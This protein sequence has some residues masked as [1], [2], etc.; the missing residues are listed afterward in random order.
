MSTSG[1]SSIF[2]GIAVD[3]DAVLD[4]VKVK[5]FE[6]DI[7]NQDWEVH[8]VSGK[9]LWKTEFH[10]KF[11]NPCVAGYEDVDLGL[12]QGIT[13]KYL[14]VKH[15]KN[16]AEFWS[17]EVP[18]LVLIGKEISSASSYRDESWS[19]LS[20]TQMRDEYRLCKI[21]IKKVLGPLG[22]WDSDKYGVYNL[23]SCG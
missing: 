6:H 15:E 23:A 22:C 20:F 14:R 10:T 21:A 1:Y 7:T 8:P 4:R 16:A 19:F 5:N 2:V 3:A 13:I 18:E 17:L 12:G 9:P 11:S